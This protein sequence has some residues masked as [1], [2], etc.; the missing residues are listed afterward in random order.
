M[1]NMDGFFCGFFSTS[2]TGKNWLPKRFP[3]E[4]NVSEFKHR[5]TSQ[6]QKRTH[7]RRGKKT[8]N[9]KTLKV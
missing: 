2:K 1:V 3:E 8:C 9:T 6:N 4:K 5:D 7:H